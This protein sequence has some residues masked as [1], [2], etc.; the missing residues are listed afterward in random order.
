MKKI[1]L[2]KIKIAKLTNFE[3]RQLIGGNEI[4]GSDNISYLP[5][6]EVDT[7]TTQFTEV[8]CQVSGVNC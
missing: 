7:D 4:G 8:T 2:K 3:K 1:E 5:P 6:C